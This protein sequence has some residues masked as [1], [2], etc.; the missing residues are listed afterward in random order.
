MNLKSLNT[1]LRRVTRS[2]ENEKSII[3][4]IGLNGKLSFVFPSF[5]NYTWSCFHELVVLLSI[6]NVLGLIIIYRCFKEINLHL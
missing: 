6:F 3:I 5:N 2:L 4:F 1:S